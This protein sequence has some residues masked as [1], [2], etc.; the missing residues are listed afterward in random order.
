MKGGGGGDE[1]RHSK[2]GNS[3]LSWG[4]GIRSREV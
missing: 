1:S 2:D 3:Q 4:G